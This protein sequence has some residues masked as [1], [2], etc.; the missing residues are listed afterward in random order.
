MSPQ[1]LLATVGLVADG[2]IGSGVAARAI[3]ESLSE[4][5]DNSVPSLREAL[6]EAGVVHRKLEDYLERSRFSLHACSKCRKTYRIRDGEESDGAKCPDCGVRLASLSV[7]KT[8]PAA[9]AADSGTTYRI[10]AGRRFGHFLLDRRIGKGGYAGVYLARNERAD[11][12]VALKIFDNSGDLSPEH[13]MRGFQR[14]TKA[15]MRLNHPNIVRVYDYG[16]AGKMPYIEMEFID[17]ESLADRVDRGGAIEPR[18]AARIVA[19]SARALHFAH[20]KGI[21][22]RDVKPQNILLSRTGEVK[23]SDFG[24]AKLSDPDV[25]STSKPTLV[26]TPMYMSPEQCRFEKLNGRSDIYSLGLVLYYALSGRLP[27][28][29]GSLISLIHAQISQTLPPLPA[30]AGA[31]MEPFE[32]IL[33]RATTKKSERRYETAGRMADDLQSLL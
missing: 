14:E 31:D 20:G 28:P 1:T 6:I 22:H 32:K 25:S 16:W 2:E 3:S 11:R 26:G 4:S 27:Y 13:F 21:I 15:G 30:R 19:A 33:T 24:L 7:G 12:I 9:L 18:E 5:G 10:S 17:G 8:P 23:V 29:E